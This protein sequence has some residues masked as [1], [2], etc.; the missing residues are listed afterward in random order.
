MI[1]KHFKDFKEFC[2]EKNIFPEAFLTDP[3]FSDTLRFNMS[4]VLNFLASENGKDCLEELN[5]MELEEE[6]RDCPNCNQAN[7]V[8]TTFRL[9]Q[10]INAQRRSMK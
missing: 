9:K 3:V 6:K 1:K 2:K 10:S 5:N 4:T 8:F 7:A